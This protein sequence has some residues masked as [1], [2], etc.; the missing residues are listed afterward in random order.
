MQ[1][2]SIVL[3]FFLAASVLAGCQTGSPL[4]GTGPISLTRN[5]VGFVERYESFHTPGAFAVTADGAHMA[6]QYCD[7]G[8][9]SGQVVTNTISLCENFH[10]MDC[11]AFARGRRIIW[12]GPVTYARTPNGSF[13]AVVAVLKG[14]EGKHINYAATAT[15]LENTGKLRINVKIGS[16]CTGIANINTQDW[17]MSCDDGVRYAGTF[18]PGSRTKY[19]GIGSGTNGDNVEFQIFNPSKIL[20]GLPTVPAMNATSTSS[21][22]SSSSSNPRPITD[23]S[24]KELCRL[25]ITGPSSNMHWGIVSNYQ[26]HVKEAKRRGFSVVD[27]MRHAGYATPAPSTTPVTTPPA[28]TGTIKARLKELKELH[29][30]GLINNDDYEKKKAELLE[31]L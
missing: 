30:S 25:A 15:K 31:Q 1:R 29:D 12:N 16:P 6:Y 5:T 2:S 28:D 23:F 4:A 17:E 24:A 7:S 11:K 13:N 18:S 21:T 27:C 3:S 20:A 22:S 26:P 8:Q 9:C 19:E 14:G 10:N